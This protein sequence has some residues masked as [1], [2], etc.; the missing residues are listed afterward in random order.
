[1]YSSNVR[2]IFFVVTLI[3]E[4]FGEAITSLG[5]KLSLGPPPGGMILAQ[6]DRDTNLNM[7]KNTML[8]GNRERFMNRICILFKDCQT[9]G[10]YRTPAR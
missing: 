6:D 8:N 2:V 7:L 10:K 3:A 9:T 1:M 5:G 4:S